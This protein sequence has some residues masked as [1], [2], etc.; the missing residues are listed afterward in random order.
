MMS[1]ASRAMVLASFL[2]DSLALG[3][4]WIYNTKDIAQ[5]FG[6]VDRLLAPQPDSFHAP[7]GAGEFTHYGD[8]TL[9]LL[10]VLAQS[11]GFDLQAF[12]RAWQDFFAAYSGY[13]DGATKNT[14]IGYKKGLGP[15]EAGSSS[16]DLA[17][18]GRIAPLV[19]LLQDRED[20]LVSAARAQTSMTHKDPLVVDSAEFFARTTL[21]VLQGQAPVA[22][23]EQAAS[24][25]YGHLPAREWLEKGFQS[26]DQ[27]TVPAIAGFGKTCHAPHAFP[28]TVQIIARFEQ[29]LQEGLVQNVMAG[30]DSAARGLLAGMVLG[31]YHGQEAIPGNW[32]DALKARQEIES[33][34]DEISGS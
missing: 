29:D 18:A 15:E 32:L 23:L 16:N 6:R 27:E 22:A 31:A 12:S 26:A 33:L 25:D 17:G 19:C 9:V 34:L 28:G 3:A 13:F 20:E 5:R 7:K 4:H 21:L 8:Q 1:D 14:L 24:R 2:G 11:R 30:G 10:R